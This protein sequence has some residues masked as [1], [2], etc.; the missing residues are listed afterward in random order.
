MV[1]WCADGFILANTAVALDPDQG[2]GLVPRGEVAM[3]C[4]CWLVDKCRWR[5]ECEWQCTSQ[6]KVITVC[7]V[8]VRSDWFR[9]NI[10][11]VN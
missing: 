10:H 6:N 5:T 2:L 7:R 4:C 8:Q 1:R 11:K 9:D 3:E